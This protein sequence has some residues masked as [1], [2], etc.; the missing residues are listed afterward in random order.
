MPST[1]PDSNQAVARTKRALAL[2]HEIVRDI[3]DNDRG[4][5]DRLPRE[6]EMVARYDVARATLREALRFLELQG[7]IH[8]QLGRGG[9]PV[10]A[11]P[12]TADFASTMALVLQFMDTDLRALL[13]LR[14]AIAPTV[15]ARAAESASRADM[16]ALEDCLARLA[17]ER[18]AP[19]FEETNR[20]FHDLLGWASGNP[21]FGLL[22]S[23]LHLLT[24]NMSE[25]LGYSA[26]ERDAQLRC[27]GRVLHA[28]RLQDAAGA[29]RQM[30]RLIAGSSAYLAERSP[31]IVAQKVRWGDANPRIQ[32]ERNG[33]AKPR[34]RPAQD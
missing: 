34:L 28:V 15:A 31:A 21:T 7:V 26:Q 17:R 20:R 6:E 23:A 2:A 12:Q 13:E 14:E 4:P 30:E 16:A 3:G 19:S 11:R 8:L 33:L 10:V 22:T 9:G 25:S 5:G 18:D 29:R 32:G 24:R 1:T 27:L